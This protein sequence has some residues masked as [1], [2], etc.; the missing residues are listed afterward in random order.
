MPAK[1]R[2]IRALAGLTGISLPHPRLFF[3]HKED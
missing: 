2:K 3:I 1:L